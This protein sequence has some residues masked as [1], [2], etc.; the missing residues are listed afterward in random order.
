ML[1]AKRF[2]F[3]PPRGSV[4]AETDP[5]EPLLS[6]V[7]ES[8]PRSLLQHPAYVDLCIVGELE[9]DES[10]YD[11]QL[12][13]WSARIVASLIVKSRN[14]DRYGVAHHTKSRYAIMSTMLSSLLAI[15]TLVGKK[16]NMLSSTL[17]RDS[18][19]GAT[20]VRGGSPLYAEA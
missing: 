9:L 1:H 15:E 16:T 8:G 5:W 7:E 11:S 14:E 3:T 13:S 17:G 18:T 10:F 6:T 19:V 20:V 12:C 4:A 2:S